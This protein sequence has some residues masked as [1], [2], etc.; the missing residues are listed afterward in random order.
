MV[1]FFVALIFKKTQVGD[2]FGCLDFIRSK[3]YLTGASETLNKITIPESNT[4]SDIAP[5]CG[6]K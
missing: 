5:L 3:Y 4:M 1:I 2:I 6:A